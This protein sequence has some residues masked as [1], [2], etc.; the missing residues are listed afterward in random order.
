MTY[1]QLV[2]VAL[3]IK[4]DKILLIKRNNPPEVGKWAMP[5]GTGSFKKF[6]NPI[7]AVK[8]EVMYD[9]KIEIINP[10]FFNIYFNKEPQETISLVY[11]AKDYKGKPKINGNSA[12]DL[13]FFT[14]EEIKKVDLAFEHNKIIEDY[15]KSNNI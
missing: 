15:L 10:T 6:S 2:T 7:D 12:S 5:G 3:V 9:L 14:Y 1:P 13:K 8:D 4:E 11:V